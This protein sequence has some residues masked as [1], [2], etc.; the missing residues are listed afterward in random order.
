MK[1]KWF[2]VKIVKC[3]NPDWWWVDSIGDIVTVKRTEWD[4]AF[5]EC[6]DGRSILKSNVQIITTLTPSQTD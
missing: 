5:Y 2:E 3:T 4:G 1:R 6:K